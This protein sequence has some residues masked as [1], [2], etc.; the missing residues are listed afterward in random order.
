[1]MGPIGYLYVRDI[2]GTTGY[3]WPWGNELDDTKMPEFTS[4]NTLPLAE[5]VI[6]LEKNHRDL[7]CKGW[8]I[9]RGSILVW[10]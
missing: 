5:P 7:P 6:I 10:R 3:G 4:G 9:S 8:R 1:M 2:Q